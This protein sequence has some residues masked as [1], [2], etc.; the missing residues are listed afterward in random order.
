MEK[1]SNNLERH[2]KTFADKEDIFGFF[3]GLSDYV[4]Y[5][6]SESLLT[7]IIEKAL[8]AKREKYDR[9]AELESKALE[10]LQ[11]SK[12]KLLEVIEKNKINPELLDGQHTS[13]SHGGLLNSLE[14]FEKGEI[15]VSGYR[16]DVLENY[17]FDISVDLSRLGFQEELKDFINPDR[18]PQNVYGNFEFSDTLK[19]SREQREVI[20][21]SK[22]IDIWGALDALSKFYK[23][24]L[25]V[26][27][28]TPWG[29]IA[30][31][32]GEG[33][34]SE[35][36]VK[37]AVDISFL[38]GE[39]GQVVKANSDTFPRQEMGR[40]FYKLKVAKFK[41]HIDRAH[42]YLLQ[43]I[44][45]FKEGQ[46]KLFH[47]TIALERALKNGE[48]EANLDRRIEAII[49]EAIEVRGGTPRPSQKFWGDGE[50]PTYDKGSATIKLGNRFVEIPIGSN[51]A[52]LCEALFD[53]PY[54]DWLLDSNVRDKFY[55]SNE[56]TF[57]NTT[58][59]INKAVNDEFG[60]D[61]LL[62][63]RALR[64]RIRKE[65]FDSD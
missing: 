57:Y 41:R 49:N 38:A 25:E 24:T 56:S 19:E 58:R 48:E 33:A 43:E 27:S 18:H 61:E 20:T 55:T 4:K 7:T 23:A 30:P 45:N 22:V 21:Q 53:L 65:I 12:G 44:P 64:V 63:Y 32:Y 37:D 52:V 5:V 2:Y 36:E 10:E 9:L 28:N 8:G 60:I 17:L 31:K 15:H 42:I 29:N 59:A 47:Q 14:R 6:F 3:S 34:R 39:W 54:G 16:T 62:K 46:D 11:K 1:I 40:D 13:F 51:Q 35:L 26:A 50:M